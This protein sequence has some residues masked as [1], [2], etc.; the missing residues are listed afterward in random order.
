MFQLDFGSCTSTVA[1]R[2]AEMIP[3]L[4]CAI[5]K[6]TNCL[7]MGDSQCTPF[8]E[9]AM[10]AAHRKRIDDIDGEAETETEAE[11]EAKSIKSIDELEREFPWY[12]LAIAE[13]KKRLA[14]ACADVEGWQVA[15]E[16]ARKAVE[17]GS[18]FA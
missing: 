13:H 4:E 17:D 15:I 10:K 18:R 1:S 16:K 5:Q 9:T 7:I 14:G 11:A 6:Q 3:W 12:E 2:P 8:T